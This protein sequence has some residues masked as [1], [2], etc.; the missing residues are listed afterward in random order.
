MKVAKKKDVVEGEPF[1]ALF[2]EK[3][4]AIFN[5][6]GAYYAIDSTCTH[7]GGP[8][9]QGTLSEDIIRCPW[10]GS[11]F[12]VKSGKV[13]GGPAGE[14]VKQYKVLVDGEDIDVTE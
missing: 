4:I 14:P 2:E 12:D 6:G 5:I 8:L 11:K 10:H 9:C 13:V 1:C 7:M 3:P